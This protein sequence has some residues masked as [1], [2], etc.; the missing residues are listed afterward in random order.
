MFTDEALTQN[1]SLKTFT[2]PDDLGKAYLDLHTKVSSGDVSIIS[3]DLRKDPSLASFKNVNDV[4]KSYVE[5]RKLIGT[6]K[7]APEKP[8][9]YKFTQLQN[10]HPGLKTEGTQ[11]F[12][13]AQLHALDIDGERADKLQV[14]IISAL[15]KGLKDNDAARKAKGL[16]T[17]T[18]LRGE[19]KENFEKNKDQIEKTLQRVGATDLAKNV[20]GDP[21]AL[22]A[23]HQILS[24]LSEDSIGRLG[25]AGTQNIT[26]KTAAQKR[27]NEIIANKEHMGKDGKPKVGVEYDKF[28]E[29][30]GRL[31]TLIG[32]A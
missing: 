26:E 5:A 10:V 12:L 20:G 18:A 9:G 8:D 29:E 25:D 7:H 21:V 19:W 11:K 27:I 14:A 15:D 13:A 17:E 3:E 22:K 16:E 23:M 32:A 2:S 4:A 28:I 30:W 1:E 6:I 31:H 24:L